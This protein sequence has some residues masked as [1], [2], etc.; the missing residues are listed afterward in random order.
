[1]M[2]VGEHVDWLHCRYAVFTVKHGDV[3][4]LCCRI[5]AYV[6]Y[7][8]GGGV[9]DD[10]D[11]IVVHSCAWRV[12]NHHI[13]AAVDGYEFVGEHIFHVAGI[14]FGVADSVYL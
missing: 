12:D 10:L 7:A 1:M 6:D 2:G 8:R 13:R 4:G 3:S 9:E 14:E 11:Y 5:A